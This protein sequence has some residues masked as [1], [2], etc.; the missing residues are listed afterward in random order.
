M[1]NVLR[2]YVHQTS[3]GAEGHW[4]PVVGAVGRWPDV[5]AAV[6]LVVGVFSF[7]WSSGFHIDMAGPGDFTEFLS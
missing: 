6:F 5:A 2:G 3:L 1:G 7:D 4:L